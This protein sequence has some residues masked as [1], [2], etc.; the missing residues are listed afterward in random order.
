[1][2]ISFGAMTDIGLKRSRNEDSLCAD[3]QL[4]LYVVCDGLGG[5]DAGDVASRLAVEVIQKHCQESRHNADLPIIG[6]Y[7]PKFSPQTNRLASAIRLANQVIHQA[8]RTRPHQASMAT[9][10]VSGV[11]TGQILSLAHVGD[12]RMYLIRGGTIQPLT[13]DHSFV[14]EQV[15]RGAMTEEEA[16]LSP[17][18]NIVTRALGID[19]AVDVE[20]DEVP[21]MS[22][23][24][25]L[26]CSDGLTR[27]VKPAEI[28]DAVRRENDPQAA[29]ERLV[30]L[31]TAA[32]GE[33]NTTVILVAVRT[34]DGGGFW[35]R[36]RNWLAPQR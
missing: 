21:L 17:Q 9:T 30:E 20:L 14:A 23:D 31:A 13:A 19:E 22:G 15:R 33:D 16:E 18:K 8:A 4:A 12:S 5:R 11:I 3:P 29:T 36:I 34:E 1:M 7:D 35:R 24:L 27:G 32:G 28:M 2:E 6:A 26:L 10:V 25:L